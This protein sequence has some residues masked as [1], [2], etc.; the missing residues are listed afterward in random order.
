MKKQTNSFIF[1]EQK[2]NIF[3]LGIGGVSMSS[4]A[5]T[6][7]RYGCKVAGFDAAESDTTR[8]LVA[9]GIPVYG[10]FNKE[11]YNGV[12]L[13]VYTGAIREDDVVF[14]YPKS[15]GI[16]MM[17]RA[18]FLGL[19]MKQCKNPIGVSGTHGKSS[20]TGMLSSIFL[21]AEG[22][23]PTVM[24]GAI[25]PELDSTYRLGSGEDFLF[26]AC[27]YQNSFLDF[28]PHIAVILNVEHDHADFFPTLEDVYVSFVKFAD[29]AK[30]GYAVFNRDNKGAMVVASR[31]VTPAFFFSSKEKADLWCENLREEKGFYSFDIFV[32]N[33]FLCSVKLSVPGEHSVSNALAA[34]S[35]AYLSGVD[36]THIRRGLEAFRGVKR[37]FEYRGTCGKMQVF[38]DYAHHPDEI[39]ATLLSAKK[40]G[41][42]SVTVVFQPHTYTRTR[43]YWADFVSSLSLAD[44]VILAD[45][46]PAREKPIPGIESEIL[47]KDSEALTYRGN[48][49][50]ISAYLRSSDKEGLLIIM[51]AGTIVNLTDLVL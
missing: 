23:D 51:G 18:K 48:F 21:S 2:P 25:L 37:R 47:A 39:R 8:K 36:A 7:K 6:A 10:Q 12:E 38:D 31:T 19:L 40:L 4:L 20:T 35:A 43:A 33:G 44:E 27:E 46:Y 30:E 41:Y 22:R 28:F 42:P 17:P 34:A 9:E 11:H 29:I 15:L 50:R 1:L 5:F 3:F 13:V 24:A 26:E 32:Q 14:S 49:D 45:I 16:P